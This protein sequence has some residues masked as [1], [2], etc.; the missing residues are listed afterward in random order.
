MDKI[1]D[2][3]NHKI[4]DNFYYD[5][6]IVIEKLNKCIDKLSQ[7]KF[8]SG[9]LLEAIPQAELPKIPFGDFKKIDKQDMIAQLVLKSVENQ[10]KDRDVVVSKLAKEKL[11]TEQRKREE[12]R[13]KRQERLL[14][15]GDTNGIDRHLNDGKPIK[16]ISDEDSDD[17]SE[18]GQ[19]DDSDD[20]LNPSKISEYDDEKYEKESMISN[21]THESLSKNH[22]GTPTKSS[23][24]SLNKNKIHKLNK[25]SDTNINNGTN[26]SNKSNS[27]KNLTLAVNYVEDELNRNKNLIKSANNLYN[28]SDSN[29]NL[30]IHTPIS[31][32]IASVSVSSIHTTSPIPKKTHIRV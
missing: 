24:L 1:N 7:Y 25:Q 29:D 22:S 6:D 12:R 27:S 13:R 21:L 2:F 32:H 9:P 18:Y 3:L 8:P 10:D 16:N 23:Q 30:K 17:D 20:D 26:N 14:A 28:K 5:D 19:D 31:S 4:P 11:E 15:N